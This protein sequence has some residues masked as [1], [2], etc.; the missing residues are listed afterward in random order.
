MYMDMHPSLQIR[1]RYTYTILQARMNVPAKLEFRLE[2][3]VIENSRSIKDPHK[4][5]SLCC[6]LQKA[7]K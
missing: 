6:Q 5:T 1:L 4:K 7:S 3:D 2:N